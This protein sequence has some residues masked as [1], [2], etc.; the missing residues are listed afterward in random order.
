[1][2]VL[3]TLKAWGE[4]LTA[5]IGG[6]LGVAW[7]TRGKTDAEEVCTR[8]EAKHIQFD[9][10]MKTITMLREEVDRM[11]D[12]LKHAEKDAADAKKAAAECGK[13]EA[14]LLK[15]IAA[16]EASVGSNI[17]DRFVDKKLRGE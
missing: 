3:D 5:V 12:R 10:L 8:T 4:V 15:R 2:A 11:T 9:E 6:G 16:L 13:R 14:D 7:L 1:M 17:I